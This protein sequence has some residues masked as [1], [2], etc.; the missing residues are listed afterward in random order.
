ML[1]MLLNLPAV[2]VGLVHGRAGAGKTA[3]LDAVAAIAHDLGW[4]VALHS[5]DRFMIEFIRALRYDRMVDFRSRV[6]NADLLMV[7]GLHDLSG[8]RATQEELLHAVNAVHRRNGKVLF[9]SSC[10]APSDLSPEL[11][12]LVETAHAVELPYPAP[13][14][15]PEIFRSLAADA[16][17]ADDMPADL[18]E[19]AS[20]FGIRVIRRQ[21]DVLQWEDLRRNA[22]LG[23]QRS[24]G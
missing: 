20:R 8:R 7:D 2:R 6:R 1:D 13:D 11:A 14:E 3:F 9:T 15:V 12:N 19:L 16:G 10:R 21:I 5:G 23:D 24:P 22:A 18:P 17:V 4:R